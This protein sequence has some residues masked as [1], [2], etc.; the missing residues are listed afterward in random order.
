[1]KKL[2]VGAAVL[3]GFQSGFAAVQ[4][5]VVDLDKLKDKTIEHYEFGKSEKGP[6]S[7]LEK[8]LYEI[9]KAEFLGRY[10]RCYK[11]SQSTVS[12]VRALEP[13]LRLRQ[14]S[15]SLNL[16]KNSNQSGQIMNVL[17]VIRK[18]K[19]WLSGQSYSELLREAFMGAQMEA[20]EFFVKKD[21]NQ[22]WKLYS[23]IDKNLSWLSSDQ[24]ADMYALVGQAAFIQQNLEQARTFY[25]RSLLV[26]DSQE[27]RE[28]LAAIQ[29]KLNLPSKV[30]KSTEQQRQEDAV[31]VASKKEKALYDQVQRALQSSDLLS[32]IEVGV[33]LISKYPLSYWSQST[34]KQIVSLYTGLL[35]RNEGRL[36][37][38]K[39]RVRKATQK[40]PPA[41]LNSMASKAYWRG[42]YN[43]AELLSRMALKKQPSREES[44]EA[45]I[46]LGLSQITTGDYKQ[47][48]ATY[49]N[50][51]AQ[52]SGTEEAVE[53]LFRLGLTYYRLENYAKAIFYFER[54]LAL[55]DQ[56]N[57]G[58]QTLYWAWNS[59]L[60]LDQVEKS[61]EVASKLIQEYPLTYY[62]MR[63]RL[64][65]SSTPIGPSFK[66]TK[67]PLV[68]LLLGNSEMQSWE[69]LQILRGSGWYQEAQAELQ[70]LPEPTTSLQKLM[71]AHLW[72]SVDHPRMGITLFNEVLYDEPEYLRWE[73]LQRFF[74]YWHKSKIEKW[75]G[76]NG[77]DPYIIAA[78]IRQESSFDAHAESSA[79]AI[80]LMQLIAFTAKEV[81]K[82][83]KLKGYTF[84]ETLRDTETNIRMGT[85]Y[86][87]KILKSNKY[88]LPL[89]LA[90]YNA[91]I[92]NLY[93]FIK[94]RKDLSNLRRQHS[95]DPAN[96]IWMDELP[97]GE[98]RFYVQ[99]VMRNYLIYQWLYGDLSQTKIWDARQ[100]ASGKGPE[101]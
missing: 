51:L 85:Y 19:S 2:F 29:S 92:G 71:F 53:G 6:S 54:L 31:L 21:R 10:A 96:E 33:E 80:G 57:F 62:G 87:K 100:K 46:R 16:L 37:L 8:N 64:H 17:A 66:G 7:V 35:A 90:A 23:E 77:V 5:I 3:F 67:L 70:Q 56:G 36:A 11:L 99:A 55:N 39:V 13:W 42:Y 68:E 101:N 79:N 84:P 14:L 72:M 63:V 26:K 89:T 30:S 81:A 18:N 97:W 25:T 59:Y 61:K 28:K 91:G 49:E 20:L 95:S 98:T 32:A 74:P 4:T 12:K 60:K 48:I 75:A 38:L 15:C 34:E 86:F 88:N 73:T 47:A 50:L 94:A 93:K 9:K 41:T 58:L 65:N 69:A 1:M 45:L 27:V 24:K 78:I 82:D 83:L 44:R 40:L 43:E 22:A 52:T 76:R